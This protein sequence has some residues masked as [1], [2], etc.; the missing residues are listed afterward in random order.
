[1]VERVHRESTVRAVPG[2]VG[3][4]ST[5]FAEAMY[6]DDRGPRAAVGQ[7]AL[8]IQVTRA[9]RLRVSQIERAFSVFQLAFLRRAGAPLAFVATG[10]P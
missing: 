3:I 4:A 7:P 5:V 2:E 8:R 9:A 1:M 10:L 6:Q